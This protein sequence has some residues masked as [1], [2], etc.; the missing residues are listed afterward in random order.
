MRCMLFGGGGEDLLIPI[1]DYSVYIY[2]NLGMEQIFGREQ[3]GVAGKLKISLDFF[4]QI[5]VE[6]F[7]HQLSCKVVSFTQLTFGN[8]VKVHTSHTC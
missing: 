1:E 2:T 5:S 6:F 4:G 3:Q 7:L 8:C